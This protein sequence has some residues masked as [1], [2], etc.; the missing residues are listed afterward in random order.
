V[1]SVCLPVACCA[2]DDSY[3]AFEGLPLL[4]FLVFDKLLID[5]FFTF[6]SIA[7]LVSL[8]AI[9]STNAATFIVVVGGPGGVIS[10]SPTSVN[11]NPGDTVTFVFQQKNHSVTQSTLNSPCSPLAGG[12]DSGFVPV[13]DGVTTFPQAQFVVNDTNPVWVYCR[14][15]GHCQQGMVFAINPGSALSQFQS[16]AMNGTSSPTATSAAP[17]STSSSASSS[18][19]TVTVGQNGQLVFSPAN[20]SA[21]VGDTV[22]FQFYQKNHTATQSSFADPCRALTLTSTTGQVGFDSGFMPVAANATTFPTYTIQI[23]NTSPVWVYCRQTGHCGQGMVFAVNAVEGGA[24]SF[25]AF[26]ANAKQLNGS[27]SPTSSSSGAS[28][29]GGSYASKMVSSAGIATALIAVV[30]GL[31]L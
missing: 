22:T 26:Q 18:D 16:N 2:S 4:N 30:F 12:F 24:N 13:A 23:N 11:A 28:S 15:T 29:T 8:A 25:E 6:A 14:Q 7:A 21:N 20:I 27:S 31:F 3:E 5:M 10:Y 17:T 19:H 9:P 1:L